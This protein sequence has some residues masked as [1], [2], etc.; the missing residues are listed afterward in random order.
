MHLLQNKIKTRPGHIDSLLSE[1]KFTT[2][3]IFA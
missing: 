1:Y 2:K 3:S